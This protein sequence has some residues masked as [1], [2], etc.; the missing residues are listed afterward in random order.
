MRNVLVATVLTLLCAPALAADPVSLI[1]CAPGFPG[2]TA[3]AQPTIDALA[4]AMAGA[5]KWAPAELKGAYY[6]TEPGGVARLSQP[7]AALALLPLALF[8]EQEASLKLSA[9]QAAIMKGKADGNEVW[10][11]V[12]KKGAIAKAEALAGYEVVSIVGFS[13]R[14]IKGPVLGAW[15]KLPEGVKF[16]QSKQV[17]SAMRRAAKGDK[18]A[19]L[20]DAEQTAALATSPFAGDLE[21]VYK[22]A[23]LPMGVL[24]T[25]GGRISEARFKALGEAL[26]KLGGTP[27]GAQALEGLWK[28]RFDALDPK[29]LEAARKAFAQ[30]R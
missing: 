17:L 10:S 6:E 12:A 25:V 26:P 21:V 29:A 1:I 2:T 14:F 13:P 9:K 28:L 20:L 27:D 15:G 8:L 7:D 19:L 22:S 5:A 30:A 11:L 3:E 16:T 18:V 24:A 4:A 23:P